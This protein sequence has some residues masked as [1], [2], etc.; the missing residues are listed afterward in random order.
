M[1]FNL[2]EIILK[3]QSISP[4]KVIDF[5]KQDREQVNHSIPK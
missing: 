2:R 4:L 5:E 3:I 1:Y